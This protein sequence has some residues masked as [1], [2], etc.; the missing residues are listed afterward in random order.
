MLKIKLE[1][2]IQYAH[3]PWYLCPTVACWNCMKMEVMVGRVKAQHQDCFAAFNSDWLPVWV[4]LASDFLFELACLVQCN[5]LIAL[6][7]QRFW[8]TNSFLE[9]DL[10]LQAV[11][12]RELNLFLIREAPNQYKVTLP[13][14]VAGLLHHHVLGCLITTFTSQQ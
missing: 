14:S 11:L 10:D 2:H 8:A 6:L 13:N 4:A 5:S 1:K 12:W 3:L 9:V 7:H